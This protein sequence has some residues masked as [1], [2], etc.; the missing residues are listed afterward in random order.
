MRMKPITRIVAMLLATL[1][2]AESMSAPHCAMADVRAINI[3]SHSDVFVADM[4]AL[5]M[6]GKRKGKLSDYELVLQSSQKD[7]AGD[8][9]N[10]ES[11]IYLRAAM[12]DKRDR[13]TVEGNLQT[14]FGFL[15]RDIATADHY[16]DELLKIA[17]PGLAALVTA[18]HEHLAAAKRDLGACLKVS[19]LPK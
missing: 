16:N 19:A 2:M 6:L 11:L 13:T 7:I 17:D 4:A 15:S 14:S 8:F 1:A 18:F 9:S 5:A 12:V 10:L 3:R